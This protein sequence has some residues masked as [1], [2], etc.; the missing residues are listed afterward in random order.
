MKKIIAILITVSCL[1]ALFSCG[2]TNE[3]DM[4]GDMFKASKPTKTLVATT[5]QFGETTLEAQYTLVTG[6]IDGVSA[7]VYE[8]IYDELISV[9]D[10][11]T[12]IVQD[13][14]VERYELLEYLDGY[15]VRKT[16]GDKVGKWEAAENFASETGPMSLN[17]LSDYVKEFKYE[18]KKLVCVVEAKN[19]AEVLGVE[20]DLPVGVTIEVTDD[21]A[22]ITQIIITY[23]L[24]EDTA[25]EV[26]ETKVTIKAFYFYDLQKIE[27]DVK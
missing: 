4:V 13:S 12:E 2:G 7:S 8:A 22:S 23:T 26:P 10:G 3:V 27:I 11:A 14:I 17:L 9:E 18:D 6:L 20:E 21:G 16:E 1:V 24:P 25:S 19:T 15:G 5:Q